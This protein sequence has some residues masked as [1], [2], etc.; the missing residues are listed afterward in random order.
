MR[1]QKETLP[2][3][4]CA[5]RTGSTTTRAKACRRSGQRCAGRAN[6][7]GRERISV[8]TSQRLYAELASERGVVSVW[9]D[10][11]LNEYVTRGA[12]ARLDIDASLPRLTLGLMHRK[13]LV[14]SAAAQY[15]VECVE[16]AGLHRL[17]RPLP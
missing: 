10:F 11:L 12:F 14:F 3:R 17:R 9:T 2:R 7:R 5:T 8:C 4:H 16:R 1:S 15:F 13:D 6:W